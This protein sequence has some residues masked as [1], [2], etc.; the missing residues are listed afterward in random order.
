[1]RYAR[2]PEAIDELLRVGGVEA[3]RA[4]PD[5]E[6]RLELLMKY[7][8]QTCGWPPFPARELVFRLQ[9]KEGVDMGVCP[10]YDLSDD[11]EDE[12]QY[13]LYAGQRIPCL[14]SQ[15]WRGRCVVRN[16]GRQAILSFG[17]STR[18]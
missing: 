1:M 16:A 13:C 5:P 18:A 15:P 10:F 3:L 11:K 2:V 6:T 9:K 14:C 17:L 7:L 8:P 12:E 4:A